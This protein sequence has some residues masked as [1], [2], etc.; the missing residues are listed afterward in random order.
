MPCCIT[1]CGLFLHLFI[2]CFDFQHPP[3]LVVID[4]CCAIITNKDR[5]YVVLYL[6]IYP[7]D[8]SRSQNQIIKALKNLGRPRAQRTSLM[9]KLTFLRSCVFLQLIVGLF[10]KKLVLLPNV[11]CFMLKGDFQLQNSFYLKVGSKWLSI[12]YCWRE[13]A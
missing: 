9:K 13:V 12:I 1:W 3:K 5:Y 2:W 6:C 10:K 8:Y 7:L 4:H 11:L